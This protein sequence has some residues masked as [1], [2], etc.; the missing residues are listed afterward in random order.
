MARTFPFI[1]NSGSSKQESPPTITPDPV[2]IAEYGR[3]LL[4]DL[5]EPARVAN[6]GLQEVVGSTYA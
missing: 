2:S 6:E 4:S 3:Y 1:R 5:T